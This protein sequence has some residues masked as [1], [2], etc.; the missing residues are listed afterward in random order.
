[1]AH[2]FLAERVSPAR[3]ERLLVDWANLPDNGEPRFAAAVGR[4]TKL[5]PEIFGR[6][7]SVSHD[8]QLMISSIS[9]HLRR[10]WDAP[11]PRHREWYIFAVRQTY[12]QFV[13]RVLLPPFSPSQDNRADSGFKIDE[14]KKREIHAR[15]AGIC[16]WLPASAHTRQVL[17]FTPSPTSIL[18]GQ[19]IPK[20][21]DVGAHQELRFLRAWTTTWSSSPKGPPPKTPFEDAAVRFQ[22]IAVYARHCSNPECPAAYFFAK[23]KGQKYCS[24]KCA[25]DGQREAKRRWW[26]ENKNRIRRKS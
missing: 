24:V 15:F 7:A 18:Q 12:G 17:P 23:K 14:K 3:A 11:D 8:I 16:S 5:Y 6:S 22:R 9:I 20:M 25:A 4:L 2:R 1:M 13:E 10:A 19:R 21:S 26:H